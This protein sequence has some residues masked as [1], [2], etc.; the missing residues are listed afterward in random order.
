M[1]G[2]D[3][4][5]F[6][7]VA[8]S[9][10]QDISVFELGAAGTLRARAPVAIQR[11]GGTGRSIVLASSPDRAFLYA[12]YVNPESQALVATFS[13]DRHTGVPQLLASTP[14]ADSVAYL[15]TDRAGHFLLG[16][17][18]AGSKVMVNA[19]AANGI[20]GETLQVIPTESKAHCIL[21]DPLNRH[22]LHTSLGGDRIYQQVFDA[23]TGSLS[24]NDPAAIAVR[25][26]AGPRFMSF[27]PDARFVYV[28]NELD[29][30]IDVFSY[31]A[32]RGLLGPAIQ[33]ASAL[34]PGFAGK[35]WAADIQL[36][37]DG[38]FVCASERTSSYLTMFRVDPENGTLAK[39]HSYPTVAQPRA[40]RIDAAGRYLVCCGQLSNS[41]VIY[42]ID[43]LEGGLAP[44]GEAPVGSNPTWVEILL[45]V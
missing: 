42:A 39:L 20:V 43:R 33:T 45:M 5:G 34:P 38:R 26:G 31:D 24:P 36:T 37:P 10:S 9:G 17:S 6:V 16:A 32:D 8:N 29:G 23:A 25:A 19:I 35:P 12:G 1:V 40:F 4:A 11:P 18:Y 2:A 30:S 27:S 44:I 15:A 28:I 22:V 21:T 41:L 13:I 7:Y 3:A 14:L